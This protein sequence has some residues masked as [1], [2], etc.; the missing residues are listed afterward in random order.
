MAKTL[1]IENKALSPL[2]VQSIIETAKSYSF[3]T[4]LNHKWSLYFLVLWQTGIRQSECLAIKAPHIEPDRI[5][6]K[7]CKKP[8]DEPDDYVPIQPQLYFELLNYVIANNIKGKLFPNSIQEAI[9]IFNQLKKKTG[10]R[11][12]LTPHG[13]R[14][15]FAFNYMEQMS[16]I[17]GALE[18]L[19]RLARILGHKDIRYT[20]VYLRKGFEDIKKDI[21]RLKF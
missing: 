13:F 10:I 19:T 14:H 2:E 18:A 11:P 21:A 20:M 4:A 7:R 15:G 8:K 9:H 16:H 12:H 17:Y 5:R 1:L 6:I 3:N